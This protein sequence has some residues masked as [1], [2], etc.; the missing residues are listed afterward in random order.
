MSAPIIDD[1]G[2]LQRSVMD[3]LWERGEGSVHD[4]RAAIS[5]DGREHA[6]TTILT[7]LQ[8]L[9]KAGWVKHRKDGRSYVYSPARSRTQVGRT[10]L[11]Q[12]LKRVFEGDPLLMF[13]HLI[14]DEQV[15]DA[16]LAKLEAMIE[17]KR[18]GGDS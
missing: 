9:E 13:Q 2:T 11:K 15:D 3:A 18:K 8:K 1:L 5:G 16:T 4:V 6:Y 14:E 12:F 10:S 7:V 17:A